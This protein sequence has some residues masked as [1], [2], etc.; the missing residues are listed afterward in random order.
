MSWT[1]A[2]WAQRVA[3]GWTRRQWSLQQRWGLG[4]SARARAAGR[5]TWVV[6][7]CMDRR[8]EGEENPAPV[9]RVVA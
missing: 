7:F 5:P 8:Q 9:G 2:R 4:A 6:H 3:V 1:W